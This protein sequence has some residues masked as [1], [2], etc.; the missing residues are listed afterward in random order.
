M[1]TTTLLIAITCAAAVAAETVPSMRG[2]APGK[3]IVELAS[4]TADLSTLVSAVK[5]AGLVDTLEGQ[6]PFTVFAPTNE[7]FSKLPKTALDFL[8]DPHN[9]D[10]LKKVLEYHVAAG[11]VLAKDLSDGESIKTVEG[12]TVEAHVSKSGVK[13]NASTVTTADV[14]AS[15]GVVHIIDAVLLPQDVSLPTESIVDLIAN[16]NGR[17]GSLVKA[18]G[19]A[20]LV[21]TLESDG[22]FTVFAPANRAFRHIPSC[23]LNHVLQ[24]KAMLK[25]VLLYHVLPKRVYA[26]EISRHDF[27]E[28]AEGSKLLLEPF[29]GHVFI[30]RYA[31]VLQADVQATN[32]NVHVINRVLFPLD[33]LHELRGLACEE[34]ADQIVEV[35]A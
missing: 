22:P 4:A 10:T 12:G 1:K 16:K 17:F 32:G 29:R 34:S 9:K 14:L 7:A 20:D 13:I 31:E 15:N 26:D 11:A 35:A 21:G 2:A 25:K 19:A 6:G 8:L 33:V 3:N 18:L 27:V 30:N 24:N 28:S 23:R 5:A